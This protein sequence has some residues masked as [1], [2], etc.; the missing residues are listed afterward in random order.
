MQSNQF[1]KNTIEKYDFKLY[2]L[3]NYQV[4]NLGIS[5][6]INYLGKIFE[7]ISYVTISSIYCIIKSRANNWVIKQPKSWQ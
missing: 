4:S 1:G 6:M 5:R 7:Y 2:F 3:S